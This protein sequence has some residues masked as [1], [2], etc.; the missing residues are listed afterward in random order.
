MKRNRHGSEATIRVVCSSSAGAR[1][2]AAA[3]FV[4]NF[5]PGTE[6]L[7]LGAT[8]EAVDDFVRELSAGAT[9]GLHRFTLGQLASRLAEPMLAAEGIAPCTSLGKE[10]LA[11]RAV[12]E[13]LARGHLPYFEP[14]ARLPGFPGSLAATIGEL[15]AAA[16][17]ADVLTKGPQPAPELGAL[18]GEYESRLSEA[19]L[20]DRAALFAAAMQAVIEGRGRAWVGLPVALLDVAIE[21]AVEGRF[22]AALL[23]KS[24]QALATVPA[25]DDRTLSALG[26][27]AA[28]EQLGKDDDRSSLGR[29]RGYLFSTEQP[30]RGEADGQVRFFSAPG[31]GRE[32]VEVARMILDE[33]RAGVRFDE[34]AVFLRL[35]ESTSSLVQAAFRRAGIPAYFAR[36]TKRPDPAGRAF[37]ALLACKTDGLSAKRFA[38]Y[39]SFGQVPVLG[40]SGAPPE[41]GEAWSHPRDE[42]FGAAAARSHPDGSFEGSLSL[43]P[44]HPAPL[45]AGRGHPGA[46]VAGSLHAPWKWEDLLVDA[47]VIGGAER[48]RRRL[49]G[50]ANELRAK[51][52]EI[53]TEEPESP[54]LTGIE[55]D[56]ANLDSLRSFALPLIDVLAAF[57]AAATWGDWRERLGA[58]AACALRRP[59]RVLRLLQE[60]QPMASVGPVGIEEVRAV[61]H[62]RLSFLEED[63]PARRYGRVFV[64]TPDQARGRRFRVVF[65]L[66]LAERIFPQ[67]PRE[68]PLLLDR[69]RAEVSDELATQEDRGRRERL[70]LRLA[71]GGAG[72]RL[73][74]SYS[75]LDAVQARPRVTSFYG[76]DVAR[77]ILGTIP[78][79]ER[80]EREAAALAGARLAWPA[81]PDPERAIDPIEH[82]LAMLWRLLHEKEVQRTAGRAQY[83]LELN[84]RL[85]RSLR[86]RFMRWERPGWSPFDG[87][88]QKTA[89]VEAA[90][91]AERLTSRPYSPST[92]EK[93]AACP[94][95]FLLSA[96]HRLEPRAEPEAIERLDPL[97][98]G[99]L[100]H[101]VQA[102]T[103]RALEREN[104]LPL[105]DATLARAQDRLLACLD[106][107]AGEFEEK[108]APPIARVWR[109]DIAALRTDLLVWLRHLA[110]DGGRWHPHRVEFGFGLPAEAERDPRSVSEPV[111][112]ESGAMLRGAVDL[113]ERSVKGDGL[114]VTDHKT[115]PDRT[116]KGLV[117][118]GGETLQ[119]VLYGLAVEA[120][121]GEPVR[122]A[123]L[124]FCTSRGGFVER[125]V[126]LDERARAAGREALT[127]IDRSI[128]AGVLPPA[129]REG[130]CEL[131]DFRIVCGPWE[132]ERLK[133]KDPLLLADLHALRSR[134]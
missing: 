16:L 84:D 100:F 101:R 127:V 8:R 11:T 119:P 80:F 109:D 124:F 95:R 19:R 116:V 44:P 50:L 82:D 48:W 123:R 102:E 12:R 57:P 7:L 51:A 32:A 125:V 3:A 10:A 21:S 35:P 96:I 68:D 104:L 111:L 66:G 118:G 134:P 42:L 36:G 98:R 59:E 81:P 63:P 87:L 37:L 46:S 108:L 9:F 132:E 133:K 131:C 78:D 88:V 39:L 15:R 31:D 122:E 5:P 72:E 13:V 65:V 120:A 99:R 45:S 71:A 117:V 43:D 70:L 41:G 105:D 103:L 114:R 26:A 86:A 28:V 17:T 126:P 74:L 69:L 2:E 91:A 54:R 76:L 38:E 30:P 4:S 85:G 20:A 58:L 1:L 40:E 34:M 52:A 79:F 62:E 115:G 23:S 25:D 27:L 49:D 113:V 55:R 47:A 89:A 112:L 18:L 53:Q 75:R 129:P 93:F 67:R 90:L 56:L 128:A 97:T 77:A 130:A 73:Y 33:A 110:A 60:L 6:L 22:V 14:V 64:A 24:G 106:E 61:L 121:L 107:V 94:Y 92:L 83:L 29:L